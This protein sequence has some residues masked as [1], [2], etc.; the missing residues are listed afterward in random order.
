ELVAL[1]YQGG[2]GDEIPNLAGRRA[3]GDVLNGGA[4]R[5]EVGSDAAAQTEPPDIEARSE[6]DSQGVA[7][8]LGIDGPVGGWH[9]DVLADRD[10][11][12]IRDVDER[13]REMRA[14][15]SDAQSERHVPIRPTGIGSIEGRPR[16]LSVSSKEVEL[17]VVQRGLGV[18]FLLLDRSV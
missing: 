5:Y 11:G 13:V 1:P 18:S 2:P 4:G 6:N 14:P 16:K 15:V 8:R 3:L 9:V 12:H 10:E 17:P 7:R